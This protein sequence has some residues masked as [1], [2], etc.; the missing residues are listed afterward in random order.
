MD[1][2]NIVKT[3]KNADIGLIDSNISKD[4]NVGQNRVSLSAGPFLPI[5]SGNYDNI[6]VET[7]DFQSFSVISRRSLSLFIL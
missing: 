4:I 5:L 3:A 1:M 7:S 6:A 2:D